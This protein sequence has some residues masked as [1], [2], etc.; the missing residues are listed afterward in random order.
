M[1]KI[2]KL[3]IKIPANVSIEINGEKVTVTGP[4]GVLVVINNNL[5][6][7]EN[8]DGV[9]TLL[10]DKESKFAKSVWGT[11]RVLV[12]NAVIGV[13]EGWS[14]Q[15][16]LVGTGYRAEIQG[17]TLVLT[18]GYSHP[19]K[20][21]AVEGIIYRVEKNI[22]TVEGINKETV[23]QMAAKIRMVRPPEPYKG[24]GIKY[25][26]EVIR[27]KVGKAAKTAA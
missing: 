23:G 6:K 16:E 1:S 8:S 4:K 10:S 7:I 27:R 26:T 12:N 24:K 15:L 25:I 3:P 17:T 22:I 11:I 14:K 21:E 2:G 9:L 5:I 20:I 13:V 18:V 19:V